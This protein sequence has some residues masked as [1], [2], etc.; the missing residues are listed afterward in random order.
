MKVRIHLLKYYLI[1][2]ASVIYIFSPFLSSFVI[3]PLGVGLAVWLGK[4]GDILA[5]KILLIMLLLILGI[6]FFVA[7]TC[8]VNLGRLFCMSLTVGA[9]LGSFKLV[10][11]VFHQ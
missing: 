11:M 5:G 6:S 4:Q 10:W 9:F 1:R 8:Y 3:Y 2:F 7:I